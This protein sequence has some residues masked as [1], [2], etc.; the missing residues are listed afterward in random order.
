MSKIPERPMARL[1][2][3]ESEWPPRVG[4]LLFNKYLEEG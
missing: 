1:K 3:Q 2:G 4:P